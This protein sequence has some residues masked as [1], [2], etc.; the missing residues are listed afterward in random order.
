MTPSGYINSVN[1]DESKFYGVRRTCSVE[2]LKAVAMGEGLLGV[3]FPGGVFIVVGL[4]AAGGVE[5]LIKV[6]VFR[7]STAG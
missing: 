1:W 6:L 4:A 5:G 7:L 3:N 2:F